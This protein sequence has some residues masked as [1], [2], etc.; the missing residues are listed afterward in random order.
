MSLIVSNRFLFLFA[1]CLFASCEIVRTLVP[2][3]AYLA[4]S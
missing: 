4:R 2:G 1:N 3:E